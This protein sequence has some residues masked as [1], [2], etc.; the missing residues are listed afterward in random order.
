MLSH[1]SGVRVQMDADPVVLPDLGPA[2]PRKERLC[3]VGVRT[4]VMHAEV[5]LSRPTSWE[6]PQFEICSP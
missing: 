6:V 2:Q 3:L 5:D 1:L 4:L